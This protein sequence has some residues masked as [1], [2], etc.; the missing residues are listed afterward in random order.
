MVNIEEEARARTPSPKP[1][2]GDS[3]TDDGDKEPVSVKVGSKS[4]KKDSVIVKDAGADGLARRGSST[5]IKPTIELNS[6]HGNIMD[7]GL[8]SKNFTGK[9]KRQEKS[10]SASPDSVIDE[11]YETHSVLRPKAKLGKIGGKRKVPDEPG[12]SLS[13]P[14]NDDKTSKRKLL[15]N[16]SVD[17]ESSIGRDHTTTDAERTG[18]AITAAKSPSSRETSQERA[19][20]KRA[21]LKRNLEEKSRSNARKKRKF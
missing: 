3:T 1:A 14:V 17:I 4:P 15:R 12:E 8:L 9:D 11:R 2:D 7:N 18:R 5:K 21:E 10:L 13:Q 16:S 19:N 20:R 6:G